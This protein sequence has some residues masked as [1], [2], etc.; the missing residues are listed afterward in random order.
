MKAAGAVGVT[1]PIR[2]PDQRLRI[3]VSSTLGELASERSAAREAI[4]QIGLTPIMFELGA[5]P[6]PP[7]ALYRA[8]LE[9]SDV[10][11]GIYWERYGWVAPDMEISGLEDE[12]RLSSAMPRLVY[13]KQPAPNREPRLQ[14]LIDELE[15]ESSVSYKPFRDAAELPALLVDDLAI[16]LTERFVGDGESRPAIPPSVPQPTTPLIGR[17][18]EVAE[19]SDVLVRDRRR[20]VTLTGVGGIGKTRLA[21]AVLAATREHF[22]DGS[23]FVDLSAIRDPAAVLDA[24]AAACGVM[25]E[26]A[27]RPVEAL[28]RRLSGCRLLIVL[29]NFE[30]VV[31]AARDVAELLERCPD[32]FLLVTSRT[33]LRVRG[34]RERPTMPLEVSGDET[35]PSPAVELFVRCARDVRPSFEIGP[36]NERDVVELCRH[37]DGLPLAIELAAARMRLLSPRQVLDRLHERLDAWSGFADLPERQRTLTATLDWS[38]ELLAA[39]ARKLFARLSVFSGTFTL[40]AAEELCGWDVDVVEELSVLVDHSL[41]AFTERPDGEPG[42]RM[43]ETV[44][45]YASAR[46][47]ELGDSDATFERLER[48]VSNAFMEAGPKLHSHDQGAT[49]R[50]LDGEVENFFSVASWAIER[51]HSIGPLLGSAMAARLF[52]QIRAHA[53]RLP[54]LIALAERSGLLD[55]M[56]EEDRTPVYVARA[57]GLFGATRFEEVVEFLPKV[58]P[59][60]ERLGQHWRTMLQLLLAISRPYTPDTAAGAELERALA[61]VSADDALTKGYVLVHYGPLLLAQGDVEG[62]RAMH[63]ESLRIAETC[64]DENLIAESHLLLAHESVHTG[65]FDDALERLRITA[66]YYRRMDYLEMKA[67]CIACLAG[68]AISRGDAVLSA[69]LLGATAALREPIDLRPWPLTGE[70]EKRYVERTREALG[71]ERFEEQFEAGRQLSPDEA[72]GVGLGADARVES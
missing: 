53:R 64:G 38:H 21:L 43:L 22:V 12:F 54:D 17:D 5:R 7:R 16:M 45:A 50:R 4:E 14:R 58:I 31:A 62:A 59:A 24:V 51:G 2:T 32:V 37:L 48:Y 6:H 56:P 9:Q 68:V 71:A 57:G 29:D 28:A 35:A 67:Y 19:I 8:Y 25:P 18:A 47:D 3:F 49:L 42:F 46:L 40:D 10:F 30:Q 41:V 70:I 69:R 55:R 52:W 13:L 36:D 11:V 23:V 65:D 44:R 60:V 72:I 15:G 26:G 61:T 20:L 33:L 66:E 34:E 1:P 27:E 39:Q 63:E